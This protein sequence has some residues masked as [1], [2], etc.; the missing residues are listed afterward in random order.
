[1]ALTVVSAYALSCL[2]IELYLFR[3]MGNED[4]TVDCIVIDAMINMS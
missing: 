3:R 1:M 4:W 2:E